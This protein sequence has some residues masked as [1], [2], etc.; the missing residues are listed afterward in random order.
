M[1]PTARRAPARLLGLAAALSLTPLGCLAAGEVPADSGLFTSR[2]VTNASSTN[3]GN[4]LYFNQWET[5]TLVNQDKR[6]IEIKAEKGSGNNNSQVFEAVL[7]AGK[8][9]LVQMLSPK[10]AGRVTGDLKGVIGEFEVK[11]QTVTSLGTLIYQ[12]TGSQGYTILC[13]GFDAPQIERVRLSYP[14]LHQAM[15][16]HAP[17]RPC[18]SN[19]VAARSNQAQQGRTLVMS[20]SGMTAVVGTLTVGLIQSLIQKASATEAIQA[21]KD[22]QDPQKRL[23]MARS[24][25]YAFNAARMLESGDVLAGSNLGQVLARDSEGRWERLDTGDTREITALLANDRQ[26]FMVGGEEGLLMQTSDAGKT[27]QAL[28]APTH[29][30][31]VNLARQGQRVYLLAVEG[32]DA[33]LYATDDLKAGT[34]QELRRE[35]GSRSDKPEAMGWIRLAS[36]AAS[37]WIVGERYVMVAANG[38][39]NSMDL[40]DGSWTRSKTS[41]EEPRQVTALRDGTLVAYSRN[42]VYVSRD[43][44]AT[45]TKDEQGCMKMITAAYGYQGQAYNVCGQGA[46]VFSTA[47]MQRGGEGGRW[48]TLSDETPTPASALFA[49]EYNDTLLFMNPE[50][51][52]YGRAAGAKEWTLERKPL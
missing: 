38:F 5:L 20:N 18:L 29:G 26:R 45:W 33:V 32:L 13:D 31:I 51:L 7:P 15:T 50:G 8:Y 9:Q 52:I 46:F 47:I 4:F 48:T 41:F 24:S 25:T 37:G 12:P 35:A 2:I 34:W 17:V 22:E 42:K 28:S 49:S 21:W 14:A 44:G 39:V 40:K 6:E 1:H 16:D 30:L 27:W 3:R 10:L 36:M 19:E 23:A 11:P 43:Q